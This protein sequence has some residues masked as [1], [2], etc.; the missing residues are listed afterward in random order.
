MLNIV[1]DENC[2]V[3]DEA[4]DIKRRRI[5]ET[6]QRDKGVRLKGKRHSK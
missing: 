3:C 4:E 2:K 6:T 1:R 5:Y